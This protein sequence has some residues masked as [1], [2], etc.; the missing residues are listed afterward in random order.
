MS[1]VTIV[2]ADDVRTAKREYDRQWRKNNPDKVR[3]KNR[4]YWEKKAREQSQN[5]ANPCTRGGET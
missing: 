1:N 2:S 4:R 5:L 3:A